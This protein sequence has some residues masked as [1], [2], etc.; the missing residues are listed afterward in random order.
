MSA[1]HIVN[2]DIAL[3]FYL[4]SSFIIF[5][6]D[7]DYKFRKLQAQSDHVSLLLVFIGVFTNEGTTCTIMSQKAGV[8]SLEGFSVIGSGIYLRGTREPCQDTTLPK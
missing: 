2:K 6:Y 7:C 8:H 1:G 5:V 4:A 3:S